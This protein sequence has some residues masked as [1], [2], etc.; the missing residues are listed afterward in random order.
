MH[1]SL[2]PT[3]EEISHIT[4]LAGRSEQQKGTEGQS[5]VDRVISETK[6]SNS[7]TGSPLITFGAGLP[8]A[9]PS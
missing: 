8:P 5:T 4:V 3:P 6:Q 2:N 1:P 7:T 9:L